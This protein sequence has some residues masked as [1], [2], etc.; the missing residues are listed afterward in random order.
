M[1][2][3]SSHLVV[4]LTRRGEGLVRD[5]NPSD[6]HPIALGRLVISRDRLAVR[7]TENSS[8]GHCVRRPITAEFPEL[9]INGHAK[10]DTR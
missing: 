2:G 3:R 4:L 10:N 9:Q 1:V 7:K 8:R 5:R 6:N